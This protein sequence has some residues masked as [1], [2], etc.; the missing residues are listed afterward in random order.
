MSEP[1]EISYE[2]SEIQCTPFKVVSEQH[3]SSHSAALVWIT[4]G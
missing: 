3:R 1:H 4:H 2:L